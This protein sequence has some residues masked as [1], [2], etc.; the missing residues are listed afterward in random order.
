MGVY[1]G[2]MLVMV[3]YNLYI[4]IS[5]REKSYFYYVL[6][7]ISYGLAMLALNGFAFQLLWPNTPAVN[8]FIIP[9]LEA[10]SLGTLALF[11]ASYLGTKKNTP[12]LHKILIGLGIYSVVT[13]AAAF[14]LGYEVAIKMVT[15]GVLLFV[16]YVFWISIVRLHM[17]V[18]PSKI[19]SDCLFFDLNRNLSFRLSQC[20][21]TTFK[22]CDNLRLAIR[23]AY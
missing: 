19:F 2:T 14:I 4:Y 7:I 18:P 15:L 5:I 1:F 11:T 16:V 10:L 12:R 23:F 8:H 17:G 3:L 21:F 13:I 9:V 22:L 6:Y 20:P